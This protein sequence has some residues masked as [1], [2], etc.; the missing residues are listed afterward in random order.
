[1]ATEVEESSEVHSDLAAPSEVV[2]VV[3][4]ADIDIIKKVD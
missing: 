2:V 4:M 1:M 3:T